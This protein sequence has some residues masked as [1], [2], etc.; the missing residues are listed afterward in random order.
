MAATIK[1]SDRD[2]QVP[3]LHESYTTYLYWG[4]AL[5]FA[6]VSVLGFTIFQ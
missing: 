6:V 5:V 1:H 3:K 2:S 4:F